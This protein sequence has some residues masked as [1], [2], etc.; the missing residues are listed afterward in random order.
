MDPVDLSGRNTPCIMFRLGL[1]TY[2]GCIFLPFHPTE[3]AGEVAAFL[4]FHA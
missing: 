1:T 3:V 2:L 4:C